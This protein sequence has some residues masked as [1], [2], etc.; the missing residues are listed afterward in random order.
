MTLG[1]KLVVLG[2]YATNDAWDGINRYHFRPRYKAEQEICVMPVLADFLLRDAPE[3]FRV[4]GAIE[5]I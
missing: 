4:V 1:V 3:N 5:V 2:D